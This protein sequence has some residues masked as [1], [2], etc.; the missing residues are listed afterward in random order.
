MS[1]PPPGKAC[2][3]EQASGSGPR[4]SA[5]SDYD[6][7]AAQ[8]LA[9]REPAADSTEPQQG[10]Q[11]Q[12]QPLQFLPPPPPPR[13]NNDLNAR[14]LRRYV[15]G[16]R[17]IL[18]VAANAVVYKYSAASGEWDKTGTEGTMFV[19]ELEPVPG[20][21]ARPPRPQSAVFILN[22]HGL[23]N[24]RLDLGRVRDCEDTD[25]LV[26]L[27]LDAGENGP[28]DREV[29]G[30]WIHADKEETRVVNVDMIKTAWQQCRG[31]QTSTTT[32]MSMVVEEEGSR[33]TGRRLSVTE[34]FQ[35]TR[36]V[37]TT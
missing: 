26:I 27:G 32:I 12:H 2:H 22:R 10:Q 34:L 20:D 5:T 11:G 30:L 16:L 7:D 29:F 17:S 19:C 28:V 21:E 3:R 9:M 4:A 18:A 37:T 13:D 1:R 23:E 25:R 8:Y 33:L 36:I 6:S 15:P 24:F 31:A 35:T 14:V